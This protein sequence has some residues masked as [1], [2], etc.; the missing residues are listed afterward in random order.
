MATNMYLK[1]KLEERAAQAEVLETLQSRAAQ[2][3]RD[4]TSDERSSFDNLIKR[5]AFLDDE[6]GLIAKA[7]DNSAKFKDIIGARQ[8]AEQRASAAEQREAARRDAIIHEREAARERDYLENQ[9]TWGERFIKSD[10]FKSYRG[11]GS[12]AGF[13]IGGQFLKQGGAGGGLEERAVIKNDS[14]SDL[15]LPAPQLWSGPS[16]PALRTPLFDAIGVVPTSASSVEYIYWKFDEPGAMAAEVPE[17]EVKP[18]APLNGEL[19]SVSMS[20]YAWWKA[21]TRQALEDLSLIRGVIDTQLRRGIIKKINSETAGALT[22]NTD[23]QSAAEGDE[24]IGQLRVAIAQIEDNGYSANAVILNPM[25][26]AALDTG[27]FP[28]VQ[29]N[30]GPTYGGP[31][32]NNGF[33]GLRPIAVPTVPQGTAFVG[34]FVE[35]MTFFDREQTQVFITDSHAD[36]FVRNQLVILAEARGKV[37]V[38]NSAAIIKCEGGTSSPAGSSGPPRRPGRPPSAGN[39]GGNGGAGNGNGG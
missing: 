22:S 17:G 27:L 34:D 21:V 24:L 9:A 3:N 13:T 36:F 2:E 6:I 33:W 30:T 1:A 31:Q 18:E 19:V 39:G 37:A 25:D 14:F 38:T 32:I 29:R 10:E 20:T 15:S 5:I 11:H 26:W 8:E 35:G 4:L 16:V 12:T 7:E 28:V 23:I